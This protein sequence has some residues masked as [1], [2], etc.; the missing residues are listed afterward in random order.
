MTEAEKYKLSLYESVQ[1]IK[2]TD[3]AII[4]RVLNTLENKE[5]LKI[6]YHSD[7]RRIFEALSKINSVNIPSI[8]EIF[9][10]DDTIVIE[11][12]IQGN[13]LNS[14]LEKKNFSKREIYNIASQLI[15]AMEVLH[16]VGIVHRDIKPG[17]I[18]VTDSLRVVL[19][20]YGIAKIYIPN[21]DKDTSL[22]GTEGYAAP[23]QYGFSQSDFRS[24]YYAFGITIRELSQKGKCKDFDSII[25]KCREFDPNNRPNSITEI[26]S[27]LERPRR[28][29]RC[30]SWVI[31]VI[32]LVA[33]IIIIYLNSKDD[34][35]GDNSNK[36]L[37]EE[38]QLIVISGQEAIN[39][40]ELIDNEDGEKNKNS[41]LPKEN[42]FS[43]ILDIEDSIMDYECL[44][45]DLGDKKEFIISIDDGS[46]NHWLV[47]SL[48][49][50]VL[51]ICLDDVF[52][53]EF[54]CDFDTQVK[55][56][57]DTEVIA[58]VLIYDFNCDGMKEIIPVM[59]DAKV[60]EEYGGY[61][62]LNKSVAWCIVRKDGGVFAVADGIM[63]SVL[64]PFRIFDVSPD[65]IYGE[66][67]TYYSLR[68]EKIITCK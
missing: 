40:T 11:E 58:D 65:C 20:D 64:D 4:E 12:L 46:E 33:G 30:F 17:N 7:K 42:T 63:E 8:K 41:D 62:L 5:Y 57:E 56:Y 15:D 34:L 23:E 44:N 36:D 38:S 29:S 26:R 53:E 16:S 22:Y 24:D 31:L 55:S 50:N 45:L 32:V 51:Q 18:I 1:V 61:I 14:S 60:V 68:N 66:F 59:A 19:I 54:T 39:N 10:T 52:S 49:G 27:L 3:D 13:T 9:W 47:A 25:E 35:L 21:Q 37:V 28:L 43:R 2:Q 6:S 67:S 48:D